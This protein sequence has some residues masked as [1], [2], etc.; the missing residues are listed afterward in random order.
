M[1][2]VPCY[3]TPAPADARAQ[4]IRLLTPYLASNQPAH[5]LVEPSF[6]AGL[7]KNLPTFPRDVRKRDTATLIRKI[8]ADSATLLKNA[9]GALP[10]APGKYRRVAVIGEDAGPN[11]LS[12]LDGGG[13]GSYPISNIVR[14]AARLPA[15]AALKCST[16][17]ERHALS[18]RRLGLG[19]PAVRRDAVGG[20]LRAC[21]RRRRADLVRPQRH[22][23][24]GREPDGRARGRCAR[25]R[26]RVHDRGARPAGP[27]ARP[28]GRALDPDRRGEQQQHDRRH[29]VR[30]LPP[31]RAHATDP[32]RAAR[33][34]SSSSSRGSTTRT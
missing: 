7:V 21:A 9:R 22:R 11:E 3:G 19:H 23:V 17:A 30:A 15:R 8:G 16:C 33:A 28:R 12:A 20:G 6:S 29:P 32:A 14:S 1:R 10:M 27:A 24:R 25:V 26:E 5:P 13:S 4:A 2:Y 18:R 31:A 34:G